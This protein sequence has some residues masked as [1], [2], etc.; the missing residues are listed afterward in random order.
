MLIEEKLY[1]TIRQSFPIPCVDIVVVNNDEKIL[2]L[3]RSN[4]PAKG[5]WWFP[6]GRVHFNETR[7]DAVHRKLKEECG[8]VATDIREVA[9][10]DLILRNSDGTLS[11]AITTVYIVHA[12]GE[13]ILDDQSQTYAQKSAPE[14]LAYNLDEFLKATIQGLST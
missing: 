3:K 8:L 5:E 14:W 11:H 4:D 12:A 2:M 6:G 13:I 7:P 1:E 9:T 10:K